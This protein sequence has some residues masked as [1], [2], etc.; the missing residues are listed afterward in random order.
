VEPGQIEERINIDIIILLVCVAF[1][2]SIGEHTP[3]ISYMT[4]LDK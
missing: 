4:H 3:A 1:K 2:H